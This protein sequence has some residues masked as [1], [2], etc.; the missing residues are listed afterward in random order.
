M[1]NNFAYSFGFHGDQQPFTNVVF[2][3]LC[4]T[5]LHSVGKQS[6]LFVPLSKI[7]VNENVLVSFSVC[8]Y[9]YEETE[10]KN[11]YVYY[12]SSKGA[13]NLVEIT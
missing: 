8:M 13:E 6:E 3:G 5:Y 11:Q 4:Y 7:C 10:V 12:T 2:F 1:K 9:S